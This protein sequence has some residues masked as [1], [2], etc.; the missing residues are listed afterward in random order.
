M[1][2]GEYANLV[3][4][5]LVAAVRAART[6]GLSR[7]PRRQVDHR[8]EPLHRRVLRPRIRQQRV[9]HRVQVPGF[10]RHG[11]RKN[12][13]RARR[14]RRAA[15]GRLHRLR[16]QRLFRRRAAH[17]ER[18]AA[19]RVLPAAR[20]P[21]RFHRPRPAS[22]ITSSPPTSAGGTS[23]SPAKSLFPSDPPL[24]VHEQTAVVRE[25]PFGGPPVR[26]KSDL[27]I[28]IDG[29]SERLLPAQRLALLRSRAA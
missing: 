11:R 14:P 8:Q 19:R 9:R 29:V 5:Y 18:L 7:D 20:R 13:V 6:Q 15:D 25:D 22:S 16:G 23:W 1:T 4:T 2:G 21:A 24:R 27:Q 3:A 26:L 12:P 10:A 28:R 17:A